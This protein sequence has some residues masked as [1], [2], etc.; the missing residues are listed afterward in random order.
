MRIN[1]EALVEPFSDGIPLHRYSITSCVSS[2]SEA[3]ED[4]NAS[5]K[6][7]KS[8]LVALQRVFHA[9]KRPLSPTPYRS[10]GRLS[11]TIPLDSPSPPLRT[12]RA[13]AESRFNRPSADQVR[14]APSPELIV[15][16][17]KSASSTPQS[18]GEEVCIPDRKSTDGSSL[19]RSRS[20]LSRGMTDS[21]PSSDFPECSSIGTN[22]SDDKLDAP[23][24][25]LQAILQRFKDSARGIHGAIAETQ[26][27][28]SAVS[29]SAQRVQR[30]INRDIEFLIASLRSHK[31][32]LCAEA[33]RQ[34]RVKLQ[35]C[36]T[37]LEALAEMRQALD[38][39]RLK[40]TRLVDNCT[41]D[42]DF[43]NIEGEVETMCDKCLRANTCEMPASSV[44]R[45]TPAIEL[46]TDRE[47]FQEQLPSWIRLT[48][49]SVP[50]PPAVELRTVPYAASL[51]LA[52]SD[53]SSS[54]YAVQIGTPGRGGAEP[55]WTELAVLSPRETSERQPDEGRRF[56]HLFNGLQPGREYAVRLRARSEAGWSQWGTPSLVATLR[57]E[58][59]WDGVHVARE[60]SV[61]LAPR[62]PYCDKT[63][64]F[65]GTQAWSSGVHRWS[66]SLALVGA[67]SNVH[68]FFRNGSTK[69]G[70]GI[71]SDASGR[72][73]PTVVSACLKLEEK[74]NWIHRG[75]VECCL[76]MEARVLQMTLP[77]F[78]RTYHRE[79]R[80]PAGPVRPWLKIGEGCEVNV[81]QH[82]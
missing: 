16:A 41:T 52:W 17:P 35:E 22:G 79:L 69:A 46:A 24:V 75:T 66:V 48:A 63:G 39:T 38:L 78:Q 34:E 82:Q 2:F 70:V 4:P 18:A 28:K 58:P 74:N 76:D 3:Q 55:R 61:R 25:R 54:G 8:M 5:V 67:Y 59:V 72:T 44:P 49:D 36:D 20:S 40:A 43:E 37:R 56:L 14:K 68:E 32:V 6:D 50:A 13:A 12:G 1:P 77:G 51:Q 73:K 27:R 19:S 64:V 30:T 71:V 45:L 47:G 62:K 29:G 26:E 7:Q 81:H 80:I 10:N 11:A 23:P 31:K 60:T 53:P 33:R 15:N 65:L 21:L 42:S 9:C 57:S